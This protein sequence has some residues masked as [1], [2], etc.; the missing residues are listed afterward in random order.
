MTRTAIQRE[1]AKLTPTDKLRVMHDLWQSISG[2][3]Q[4]LPMSRDHARIIDQRLRS[5][6]ASSEALLSW[7]DAVKE[8]R[9]QVAN[10]KKRKR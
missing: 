3:Q 9:R 7:D 5:D 2:D 4:A 6:D 8:A 1:L 10:A